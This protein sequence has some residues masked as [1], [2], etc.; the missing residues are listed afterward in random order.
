MIVPKGGFHGAQIQNESE[1]LEGQFPPRD[2]RAWEEP[3]SEAHARRLAALDLSGA[4][5]CRASRRF[6]RGKGRAV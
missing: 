4:V 6:R 1:T 3:E 5:V 2:S